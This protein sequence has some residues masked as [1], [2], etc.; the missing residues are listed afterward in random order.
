MTEEEKEYL[1]MIIDY[2]NDG[3]ID[4]EEFVELVP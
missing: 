3:K 2:K 1:F 4:Y